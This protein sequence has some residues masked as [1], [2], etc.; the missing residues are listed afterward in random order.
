MPCHA[1]TLIYSKIRNKKIISSSD[2]RTDSPCYHNPNKRNYKKRHKEGIA[3]FILTAVLAGMEVGAA[4][5]AAIATIAGA[6]VTTGTAVGTV[7]GAGVGLTAGA[8]AA[9]E[10][11]SNA[12]A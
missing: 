12:I 10:T 3:M 11:V 5:G 4:I 2:D 8:A 9:E 1:E 7:V 6:S